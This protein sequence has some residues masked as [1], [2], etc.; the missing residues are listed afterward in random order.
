MSTILPFLGIDFLLGGVFNAHPSLDS[1][2]NII[3]KYNNIKI[4]KNIKA[5]KNSI[6]SL[7]I[8]FHLKNT[9]CFNNTLLNPYSSIRG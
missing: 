1:I 6:I 7:Y 4:L 8:Y 5:F 3:L 2:Y 9:V